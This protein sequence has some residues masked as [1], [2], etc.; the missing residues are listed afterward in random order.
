MK[1]IIILLSLLSMGLILRFG[2][3]SYILLLIPDQL[4][5]S[6]KSDYETNKTQTQKNIN[7]ENFISSFIWI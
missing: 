4:N 6:L 3:H 7:Q 1:P 2:K 5:R